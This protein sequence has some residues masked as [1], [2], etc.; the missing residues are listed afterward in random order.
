MLKSNKGAE[1]LHATTGQSLFTCP[2]SNVQSIVFSLN[3]AFVAFLL[4]RG[5]VQIWNAA[6]TGRH[7]SIAVDDDV[8][9]IAL[10]PDGSQLAS[11]SPFHMKLWDLESE[12]CLAHL[13][14]DR[15]L[16]A[17]ARISFATNATG[18]S[19]FKLTNTGG[20][21]SWRISPNPIKNSDGTKSWFT[22]HLLTYFVSQMWRPIYPNHTGNPV[23]NRYD[24]TLPM[25]FCKFVP[26]TEKWSNQDVPALYQSGPLNTH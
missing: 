24:T 21:Q 7:K 13:K 16:Q 3:S 14:F 4:P 1:I 12:G 9:H 20:A 18:V 8:F 26:T 2:V 17:E 23:N 25:V 19:V 15:L 5:T 11:L 10:S 22:S 6:Y